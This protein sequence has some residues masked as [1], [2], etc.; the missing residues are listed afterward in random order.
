MFLLEVQCTAQ[1]KLLFAKNWFN[2]V[3]IDV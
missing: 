1:S 3:V 2:L